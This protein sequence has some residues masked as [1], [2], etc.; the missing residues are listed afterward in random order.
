MHRNTSIFRSLTS[1]NKEVL[2][3]FCCHLTQDTAKLINTNNLFS[4][5]KVEDVD[6]VFQL[7]EGDGMANISY[8]T[9]VCFENDN[10][11]NAVANNITQVFDIPKVC[12]FTKPPP[13]EITPRFESVINRLGGHMNIFISDDIHKQWKIQT[14][15]CLVNNVFESKQLN[16]IIISLY[17][18][19]FK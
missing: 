10:E 11:T 16:E 4:V 5:E 12:I 1:Q 14:G 18:G 2:D 3:L 13:Q 6:N 17:K 9:V 7:P 19:Y 15:H 8:D